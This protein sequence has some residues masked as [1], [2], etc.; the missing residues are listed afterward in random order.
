[1]LVLALFLFQ[2]LV[3]DTSFDQAKGYYDNRNFKKA[4]E[5]FEGLVRV[6][7][8]N[9]NL[10]L[11]LGRAYGRWA[12]HSGF[13]LAPGRAAKARENFEEAARLDPKNREAVSDL[14]QYYISAP[15]FLGG[16]RDKARGLLK[17]L[18]EYDD[19]GCQKAKAMLDKQKNGKREDRH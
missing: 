3:P 14:F 11:W 8:D 6:E 7:P 1:M 16:G 17:Y 19:E 9:S 18:C 2:V 4:V 12:E 10:H 13:F 5:A 15:G